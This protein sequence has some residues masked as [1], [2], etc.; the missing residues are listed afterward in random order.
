MKYND[1]TENIV[2]G[3]DDGKLET[4]SGNKAWWW[5]CRREAIATILVESVIG[6]KIK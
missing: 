5:W 3:G 4:P 6:F 1:L 2:M